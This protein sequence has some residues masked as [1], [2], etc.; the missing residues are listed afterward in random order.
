MYCSHAGSWF[1]VEGVASMHGQQ[2]KRNK[3]R[4]C[5]KRNKKQESSNPLQLQQC[6]GRV[7]AGMFYNIKGTS[8]QSA[9]K[10][11]LSR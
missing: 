8:T 11:L 10:Q 7:Q 2:H 5:N 6:R 1:H 9:C 3:T 4:I